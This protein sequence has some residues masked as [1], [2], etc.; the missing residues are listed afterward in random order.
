MTNPPLQAA[1]TGSLWK[2]IVVLILCGGAI[3]AV[4]VYEASDSISPSP[5]GAGP[6]SSDPADAVFQPTVLNRVSPPGEPLP[7]MVWIP[8]GEFSMGSTIESESLCGVPGTTADALPVHRV[9]VDGFWMD[10]TE[11]TNQQFAR[12]VEATGYVTVAE[13]APTR[14]EF[15]GP[16][17]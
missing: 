17:R 8:G 6:S 11:V 16:A 14:E 2:L 5:P 13:K 7:G 9:Y 4:A 1:S 12:F 3:V 10:A 15:P